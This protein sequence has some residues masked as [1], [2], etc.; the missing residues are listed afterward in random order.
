M[1]DRRAELDALAE[2]LTDRPN[3]HDA[4]L[5]KSFTDRLL[6][7]ERPPGDPVPEAVVETLAAQDCLPASEVYD[8]DRPQTPFAGAG[9]H[10][11]YRFVDVQSRGDMQSYVVE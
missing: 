1:S 10:E 11:Q 2:R 9:D 6:V 7:V 8:D 5:A 4:Y 3:I